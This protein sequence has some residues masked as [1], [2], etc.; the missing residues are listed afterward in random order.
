MPIVT[1]TYRYKRPPRKRAKGC[2]HRRAG[3]DHRDRI[4]A[5]GGEPSARSA[6]R[7]GAGAPATRRRGRC[8][9]ARTRAAGD[10]R[11]V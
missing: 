11:S 8:V 2:G 6:G 4:K 5:S 1:T 9:V 10:Q 7:D 3:R